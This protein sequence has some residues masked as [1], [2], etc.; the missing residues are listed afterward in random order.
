MTV[1]YLL[2]R[3]GNE[4]KG[5]SIMILSEWFLAGFIV[6]I[7]LIKG[8]DGGFFRPIVVGSVAIGSII[9]SYLHFV[10]VMLIGGWWRQR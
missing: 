9:V 2:L 7:S 6:I 1:P 10:T 8:A 5:I 4:K 3:H